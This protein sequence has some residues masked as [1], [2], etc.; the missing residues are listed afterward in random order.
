MAELESQLLGYLRYYPSEEERQEW[1]KEV[2]NI[3]D[4]LLH[5]RDTLTFH[6]KK[7]ERER[8]KDAA[9]WCRESKAVQTKEKGE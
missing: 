4:E 1:S 8:E 6:R 9:Q 3:Y 7:V 5:A 2:C